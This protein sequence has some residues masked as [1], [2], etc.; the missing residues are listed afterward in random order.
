M[1]NFL[2]ELLGAVFIMVD[3]IL[4]AGTVALD[5]YPKWSALFFGGIFFVIGIN[6]IKKS[7]RKN[8]IP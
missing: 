1:K 8:G 7:V 2:Y 5:G 6:L 3:G 4:L